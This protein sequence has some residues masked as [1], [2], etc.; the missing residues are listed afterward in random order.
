MKRENPFVQVDK[1]V[2]G[3][4]SITWKAKAILI[5]LLSLPPDWQI[6]EDEIARH[7]LDGKSAL[8]SGIQELIRAGYIKRKQIRNKDGTFNRYEY[9]VF[10]I[11][12]NVTVMRKSDFGKSQPIN[13][14]LNN[15]PDFFTENRLDKM[16][17]SI[18]DQT[19]PLKFHKRKV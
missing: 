15:T 16:S 19:D 10:E 6:Y 14:D 5:Y 8:R 7:A 1:A 13:K 2:I 11:P 17:Q 18:A 9:H 12:A 4:I 3:N